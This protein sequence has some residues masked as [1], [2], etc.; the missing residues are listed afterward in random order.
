MKKFE[1]FRANP[2]NSKWKNMISREQPL[3]NKENDIRT[4]FER[5]YTRIIHSTAYRRLRHK[6]QVFFSPE[7]DH[8]C[9]RIE[10][11]THVESISYTIANYLGLNTE[12]TKAISVAHDIGHSPFGH[13]GEHILSEFSKKDLHTSF[14]HEKNGLDFADKIELLEDDERFKQNLDL[15]YAVRDGIISHC[16]EI[17]ENAL[18]PRDEFIDL[19]QY[20][21]PNQYAPYSWEACV[22]K[23]SDKISYIGRDIEDAITLG[24]L[25]NHL[26]EMYEL[27]RISP[28]KSINNTVL[29]HYLIKDLCQNSSP[30]EGL[31]FSE[32]AFHLLNKIK[33]FNCLNIY[34]CDR[35]KPS[36]RYFKLVLTEI[37]NTLKNCYDGE[38]TLNRLKNLSKVSRMLSESFIGFVYQYYD[39]G[40]RDELKLK[41]RILFEKTSEV[42]YCRAIIYYISGM[43]DNFAI[44]IYN[45]IIG[46]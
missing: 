44:D 45:D 29:I 12:L 28:D 33:N 26:D 2:S 15:T 11:V 8:I 17:D 6:T 31:C 32:E 16:G 3:Y 13:E 37:Y 30:T 46:F 21:Y 22:V 35:I 27:L 7:N 25:D 10:H 14:W 36:K 40:N 19:S 1:N 4:D 43:T 39:Y 23:I 24:I 42:D 38:N 18:K 9:T 5:D 34:Q 41:N 20:T